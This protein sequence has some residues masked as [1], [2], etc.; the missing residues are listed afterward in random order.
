MRI[1]IRFFQTLMIG[2]LCVALISAS[3]C[4]NKT[5]QVDNDEPE[6][7]QFAPEPLTVLF[8]GTADP[9]KDAM[10]AKEADESDESDESEEPNELAETLGQRAARQ[11]SARRDGTITV[12]EKSVEELVAADFQIDKAIDVVVFSPLLMGE[13]MSRDMLR[14]VP[15]DTWKSEELTNKTILRFSRTKYITYDSK[16]FAIPLGSPHMVMMYRKDILDALK[17]KPPTTW[18]A[19]RRLNEKLKAAD[20][21]VFSE[22]ENPSKRILFPLAE[23]VA[24]TTLLSVATPMARN[25]GTLSMVFETDKME[26]LIGAPPFVEALKIIRE[27]TTTDEPSKSMGA[28]EVYRAML[29]GKAAIAFGWPATGFDLE[30]SDAESIETVRIAPVPGSLRYYDRNDQKWRD[31]GK[32]QDHQ[33]DY[34]G[35]DGLVAGV[36]ENSKNAKTAFQ[37][38]AWLS[39]TTISSIV[40][41]SNPQVGPFR[42]NH[43]GDLRTWVGSRLSP[44]AND[45]LAEILDQSNTSSRA[46]KMPPIPRISEY[47]AALDQAVRSAVDGESEPAA[48]LKKAADKWSEISNSAGVDAQRGYL[49]RSEGF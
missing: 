40:L 24:D 20:E 3:G 48:A 34:I 6:T 42:D 31:F 23:G 49:R 37:F 1:Q 25:R 12:V 41:S 9:T 16:N 2:F 26:P 30:N 11:W 19:V 21:S 14:P 5:K 33:F 47:R 29:D 32:E 13:W 18:K 7:E 45:D 46:T 15:D 17:V 35:F 39:S 22:I 10:P 36:T 8:V 38:S 27:L 43:L 4:D 44:D 28:A